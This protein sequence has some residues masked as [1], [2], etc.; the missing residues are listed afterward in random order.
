MR[1]EPETLHRIE[2]HAV[3]EKALDE[4][5]TLAPHDLGLRELCVRHNGH[6]QA[7]V[8]AES[9]AAYQSSTTATLRHLRVVRG[10]GAWEI[11]ATDRTVDTD[12]LLAVLREGAALPI[13]VAGLLQPRG[14]D[15]T[16]T[17]LSWGGVGGHATRIEWWSEGPPEWSRLIAWSERFRALFKPPTTSGL[18][19]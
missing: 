2:D 13:P 7:S 17:I 19:P 3:C 1:E 6:H 9:W 12:E 11:T 8:Q 16:R 10:S 15:G 5:E 18:G 4:P 14:R